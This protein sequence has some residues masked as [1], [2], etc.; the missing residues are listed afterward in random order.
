MGRIVHPAWSHGGVHCHSDVIY[1]LLKLGI[2]NGVMGMWHSDLELHQISSQPTFLISEWKVSPCLLYQV[3]DD[4]GRVRRMVV[5]LNDKEKKYRKGR[6][7]QLRNKRRLKWISLTMAYQL[8][9]HYL[10]SAYSFFWLA[11]NGLFELMAER[12][13]WQFRQYTLS[14]IFFFNRKKYERKNTNLVP[15]SSGVHADTFLKL[16]PCV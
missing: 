16:L 15:D 9:C 7:E 6:V 3:Y 5:V 1:M 8:S 13:F 10:Q 11:N 4:R 14:S 12:S 2:K